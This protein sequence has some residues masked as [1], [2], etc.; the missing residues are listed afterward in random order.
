[1]KKYFILAAVAA[2]FAACSFDKDMGES[3]SQVQE[4][5]VPIAVASAFNSTPKSTVTRSTSTTVQGDK[6]VESIGVYIY[7]NNKLDTDGGY[8]FANIEFNTQTQIPTTAYYTVATSTAVVYPESKTQ[9]VDLYAYA[10]YCSGTG[11][12]TDGITSIDNST[13]LTDGSNVAT[14][15]YTTPTD[16]SSEVNYRKAD[17]LY[18]YNKNSSTISNAS[19]SYNLT[20]EKAKAKASITD[21]TLDADGFINGQI[22]LPMKHQLSKITLKIKPEG[23]AVDKL[24]EATVKIYADKMGN[25]F[26]LATGALGTAT[27]ATVTST[28]DAI[29]LTSKLGYKDDGSTKYTASDTDG[30]G[31]IIESSTVKGYTA[32]GIIV[33]QDFPTSH[34]FLTISLK[35]NVATYSWQNTSLTTLSF[36]SGKEYIFN[37]KVKASGL[38]VTVQVLNWE[39]TTDNDGEAVL[40]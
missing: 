23:M 40:D 6:L 8:G 38:T 18:G 17:L 28:G 30:D 16:Q 39:S 31:V 20:A 11:S 29:T 24:E 32:S 3:S 25:T 36:D 2:T 35:D 37:I 22:Y 4:E 33:P 9:K 5:R 26:D 7:K 10:P 19:T 1:M 12:P 27:N 34:A 14:I 21:N 13:A 15:N